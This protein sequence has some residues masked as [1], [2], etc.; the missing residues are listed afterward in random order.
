M[1][2]PARTYRLWV[3][4]GWK[5]S[6]LGA[7]YRPAVVGVLMGTTVAIMA[8][9]HITAGLFATL[10]LCWGFLVV[11][12]I[13]AALAVTVRSNRRV[14]VASALD[15]LF[16]A[17]APWSLWLLAAAIW[18]IASSWTGHLPQIYLITMAVPFAWT[19]ILLHAFCRIV[20]QCTQRAAIR[21]TI[22]HQAI[23]WGIGLLLASLAVQLWP[24]MVGWFQ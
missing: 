15:L 21:R 13:I 3:E 4:A 5:V 23:V 20:L 1:R 18:T 24:R 8:T 22:A 2:A 12:Q 9:G 19:L 17:H 10:I 7:L 11:L 16:V 6:P 14:G